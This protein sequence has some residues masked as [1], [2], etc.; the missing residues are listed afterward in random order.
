MKWPKAL[1]TPSAAQM[2]IGIDTNLVIKGIHRN[3]DGRC[4][5]VYFQMIK[6]EARLRNVKRLLQEAAGDELEVYLT[7]IRSLTGK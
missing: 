2:V 1:A 6:D 7:D 4:Q 3:S 5:V